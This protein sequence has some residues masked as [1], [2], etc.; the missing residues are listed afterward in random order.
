MT[1]ERWQ[2]IKSVFEAVE[3]AAPAERSAL[4]E[5]LCA[6]DADLRRRVEQLL[7]APED[8]GLLRDLVEEAAAGVAHPVV[9]L[10]GKTLGAY[11][12]NRL[13]GSGGMGDVYSAE[14]PRLSRQ[15][16]LKVLPALHAKDSGRIRRFQQEARAASALNHPNIV[17]VYDFGQADG[18]FYI[19]T[20]LV[21]GRTLRSLIAE[22]RQPLR[23]VVE[24]G[25]QVASALVAAHEAGI[26]HRDIKPE[27]IMVRPDGY[28]KVLDFGLAK[29]R[30]R[31]SPSAP[32][33]TL[34]EAG[35]VIG[36]TAY[37][38]PEQARGL[39]VDGRSDLF[40]LAVVLYEM[41]TGVKPFQGETGADLIAGILQR[42]PKRLTDR[43]PETPEALSA[44][45][46]RCLRK[47]PDGRYPS[48]QQLLADL[49]S[50]QR[51][52]DSGA[53]A[54]V[55]PGPRR[56]WKPWLAGA[57]AAA[58][59][60]VAFAS[61]HQK[62][63]QTWYQNVR[64]R[65]VPMEEGSGWGFI[66]P[67][68]R[69]LVMA[70]EYPGR[71]Q[72]IHV[73]LLSE[74]NS[75]Q[76]VP[77]SPFRHYFAAVPPNE[78]YLYYSESKVGEP[79][80]PT[81]RVPFLGGVPQKVFENVGH[82]SFSRDGSK[83]AL[84]RW[85]DHRGELWIS[86]P[87]GS[88]Q[89]CLLAS[90]AAYPFYNIQWGHNGR[91]I[92][93]AEGSATPKGITWEMKAVGVSGGSQRIVAHLGKLQPIA[94]AV[95]PDG[96]GLM[97]DGLDVDS[98]LHQIWRLSMSG[99]LTRITNDLNEYENLAATLDGRLLSAVSPSGS[100]ELWVIEAN[101]PR[102]ARSISDPGGNV[103]GV[104]WSYSGAIVASMGRPLPHLWAMKPDGG[105]KRMLS[106]PGSLSERELSACPDR[107]EIVFVSRRTA[108]TNI[109]TIHSDGSG[110]RQVTSGGS[111]HYPQC[112]AGGIVVY[113]ATADNR[114]PMQQ[115]SLAGGRPAVAEDVHENE[116]LTGD[117]RRKAVFYWDRDTLEGR[118]AVE[119]RDG[120]KV[121][122]F[123]ALDTGVW[124]PNGGGIA[125][126][127]TL[128][129]GSELFYQPLDGHKPSQLTHFGNS[130]I[131]GASWS[132]DGRLIVCLASR[133][134]NELVLI[135]DAH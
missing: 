116:F 90:S 15:V 43:A 39:M 106:A 13:I 23:T 76:V 82:M 108:A 95:L 32:D 27:N 20:E 89:R 14:D 67:S 40:S 30:E 26:V 12:V 96:S 73:R 34:T 114:F 19:T 28:L 135:E 42:E 3:T 74:A 31:S 65:N 41:L 5:N 112:L 50:F 81:F 120:R 128:G 52:N 58:L 35:S 62:S 46:H 11:R 64:L 100:S 122:S 92:L 75:V 127:Q 47:D 87:D 121:M 98:G 104:V 78:N 55:S 88:N 125:Y 101:E 124:E 102:H 70:M 2:R 94:F 99:S 16:A 63:Q 24:V 61:I 134:K 33:L 71:L 69:Y 53:H 85:P 72:A 60:V 77:P 91:E 79:S 45:L 29:L 86:D 54:E 93:Y 44:I 22:G 36:T 4:L 83:M 84:V 25:V 80:V 105:E 132:P 48:S 129:A 57:A 10:E 56:R 126:P 111:D 8:G 38:S 115:V 103:D 17:T 130:G 6:G 68:G 110:L 119:M 97:V 51:D 118:I 123:P 131:V 1:P 21:Q 7:D 66:S 133:G 9:D 37:M 49:R 109:W 113:R 59:V 18:L 117:G 107:D